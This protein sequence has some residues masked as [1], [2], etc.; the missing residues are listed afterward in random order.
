MIN[1]TLT[2]SKSQTIVEYILLGV[3]LCVL[4]LRTTLTESLTVQ[5]TTMPANLADNIYTLSVSAVLIFSFVLWFVWSFCSG[6]FSYRFTGIEIG[7]SLFCIAAVVAGFAA[8]NK[9]LAIT[10]FVTLLAPAV[11]AILLVQILDSHS[12][13]KLLLCVI[14]ALAVVSAYQSAEQFFSSNQLTIDQYEQAPQTILEQLG[15][16][17][18]TFAQFLFEHRL[19]TKGVRGFFTTSNSAG[20]FAL[21]A[22]FAAIALFIDKFKTLSSSNNSKLKTQNSKLYIILCGIAVAAVIFAL[23]I[24]RSKGVI[25]SSFFAVTLFIL[26]LRFGDWAKAHKQRITITCFLLFIVAVLIVA[27]YG[28][29]HGRLPGGNSMLVRWQYWHASAK[30]FADHPLTGV[31][32]GNFANFYPH[33]KPAEALESVADPHNFLLSIL[34]QYGTLG[35]IGFLAMLFIPLW[36]TITS[37]ETEKQKSPQDALRRKIQQPSFRTIA[38]TYLIIVSAV[39]LLI[40]PMIMRTPPGDTFE[41]MLY[42]ILV[43]YVAP[44]TVF[45]IGFWLLTTESKIPTRSYKSNATYIHVALFCAVLGVMLHNLIDFAIFEPPVLTAFWAVIAALIA[46]DIN[47]KQQPFIIRTAPFTKVIVLIIVVA[48]PWAYLNY[49]LIP[50]AESTTKILQAHRKASNGFFERAYNLLAVAADDDKLDSTALNLNGRL[51]LQHYEDT[52]KKQPA[53]LKKAEQCFLE[54]IARDRA[55]YKNYEK[56]C[57]VY[58]L[59][60]QHQNAYDFGSYAA[61]RYPGSATIQFKLAQIAEKLHKIDT[62]VEHYKNTVDIED[63]FRRQFQIMYPN[64]EIVSRLDQEKY[65]LAKEKIKRPGK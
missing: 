50:P 1:S 41:V 40:R 7:L 26:L 53:L 21:L 32:P 24:T 56:L 44:A 22:T 59:L 64:R 33:Y 51:Y 17:S 36:K 27:R 37:S 58:D 52:G 11:M 55:N 18:G 48:I 46:T 10:N 6:R 47:Q 35:L 49:C 9:R 38:I 8:S 39:L 28:L 3:C 63:S 23:V 30:M 5:S 12:K 4:A 45:I 54:A 61:E 65:N 42:L 34:T 31:G 62:A 43:L 20:S 19:Y 25:I 57:T 2:K 16:Q 14:A 15:I 29:T 60:G 13:I